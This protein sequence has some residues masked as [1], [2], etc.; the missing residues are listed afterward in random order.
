QTAPRLDY[1]LFVRHLGDAGCPL[2]LPC[3]GLPEPIARVW[4]SHAPPASKI[5][6]RVPGSTPSS[7]SPWDG[8]ARESVPSGRPLLR[9][10]QKTIHCQKSPLHVRSCHAAFSPAVIIILGWQ[11][12]EVRKPRVCHKSTFVRRR[13]QAL[14][15]PGIRM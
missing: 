7:S 5:P 6:T 10:L 14:S 13:L 2:A 4:S 11:L 8:P 1:G 15:P 3:A 9:P 12:S